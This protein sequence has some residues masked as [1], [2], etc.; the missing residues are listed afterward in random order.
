MRWAALSILSVVTAGLL[1]CLHLPAAFLL[2]PMIAAIF[3]GLKVGGLR[4][5]ALLKSFAQA[6]I[7]YMIA[8]AILD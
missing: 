6:A 3:V 7:G 2:G 8:R 4:L 1:Q 5:R